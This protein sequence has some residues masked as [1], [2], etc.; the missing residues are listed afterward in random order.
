M[1]K[2]LIVTFLGMG[3]VGVANAGSLPTIS[4]GLNL[5]DGN[6][7]TIGYNL[8]ADWEEKKR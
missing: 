6:S 5:T 2:K 4:A 3:L 8:G 1:N 7:E